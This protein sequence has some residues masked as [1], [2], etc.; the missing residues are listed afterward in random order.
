MGTKNASISRKDGSDFVENFLQI[1]AFS[2]NSL[3]EIAFRSHPVVHIKK[4]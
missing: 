1:D 2:K 4:L 3:E